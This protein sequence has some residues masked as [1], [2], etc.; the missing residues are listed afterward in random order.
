M[1]PAGVTAGAVKEQP[2]ISTLILHGPLQGFSSMQTHP[3]GAGAGGLTRR[4]GG[5]LDS[6]ASRQ[7]RL[8]GRW[9]ALV[10]LTSSMFLFQQAGCSLDPD[11]L[12]ATGMQILSDVS[13]F[14]LQNAVN[15]L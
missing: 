8:R 5:S 7:S 10:G 14:T 13:L 9:L 4:S 15:G 3:T 11:I 2:F 1:D 6:K 12:L